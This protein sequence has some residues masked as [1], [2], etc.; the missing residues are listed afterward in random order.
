MTSHYVDSWGPQHFN[1]KGQSKT[2]RENV[3]ES[4]VAPGNVNFHEYVTGLRD[5]QMADKTL[6]F[7]VCKDVMGRNKHLNQS[8]EGKTTTL[9][10]PVRTPVEQKHTG[11]LDL[12]SADFVLRVHLFLPSDI[13]A[14]GFLAFGFGKLTLAASLFLRSLALERIRLPAFLGLQF[15][16]GR[17]WHS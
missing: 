17:S 4:R 13:G 6:F 1:R 2:F 7:G 16:N 14:P 11:R 12:L 8:T 10:N 9:T 15:A 3:G 5:A